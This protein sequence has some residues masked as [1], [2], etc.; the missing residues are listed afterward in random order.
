MCN[1]STRQKEC[2]DFLGKVQELLY[3]HFD[4]KTRKITLS[5][6]PYLGRCFGCGEE[7]AETRRKRFCSKKCEKKFHRRYD[8]SEIR[9][10]VRRRDKDICQIC[11]AKVETYKESTSRFH[12]VVLDYHVDH[13]TEIAKGYTPQEQAQLFYDMSNLQLV[14]VNCHKAKTRAFLKKGKSRLNSQD[15]RSLLD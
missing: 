14:C 9:R 11:G 12:K 1:L 4:L 10:K 3:Q 8:W 7:L 5:K 2:S 15:L 6:V 13:I